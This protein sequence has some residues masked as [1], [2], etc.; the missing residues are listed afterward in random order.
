[1]SSV[2][3]VHPE[4]TLTISIHQAITK[5]SLFQKNSSLL[6]SPYRVESPVSLSIFRE[7]VSAL[8]GNVIT[9][10]VTNL[11][12]L[13]RLCQE[14]G[15]DEFAAKLSKFS[16]LLKDSQKRQ[17]GTPLSGMRS[18]LLGESFEFFV[19]G[20]VIE[21][22]IAE[23]AALFPA[24]R[25]QLSVDGCAR[26]FFVNCSE[27]E[28]ADILSLQLLLSGEAISVR[29]SQGLLSG[30]LGNVSFERLFLDCSK[31]DI[32]MNLSDLVIERRIDLES[33]DLSF[34]SFEALESLFLSESISVESEDAL[35]Q[36]I[37]KLSPD[38][39]NLLSHIRIVF[40][41]EDGLSLLDKHFG[42][43]PESVWQCAVERIAHPPLPPLL[44]FDSQII[45]DIPEIFAE[46]R[47]KQFQLLWRGSRDG[48]GAAE[49]HRRCDGHGNTLT[50]ILDT[51]GNIFGGFTPVEW[52]S[53]VYSQRQGDGDNCLKAD[54]S[55]KSFLFTLKNPHN[56]PAKRFAL[57]TE[58]KDRA[59]IC[60]SR[61]CPRFGHCT[62]DIS[63]DIGVCDN[64]NTDINNCTS[65]GCSYTNDNGLYGKT[66]FTG[67]DMFQVR[68][69]EVFEI[70]V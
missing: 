26:K 2:I 19:N 66:F 1:M 18:S 33:S 28:A 58:A 25:E 38:Y 69:I 53:R 23:A 63:C 70:T 50:V 9:I 56:I 14:F 29:R 21:I 24:V 34:L 57:K 60:D 31:A 46:F 32:R 15:F 67:S 6:V 39:R 48:F 37:L 16:P 42:I 44:P 30:L 62:F 40:L 17:I 11:T 5:C 20:T 61:W 8:E 47:K 36:F 59:I 12:G 41:S 65:L 45:S 35:L 54:E 51:K 22:D 55:L 4:E 10:T 27:I 52:E 3:L 49:F 68:E 64:C 13:E 7:F 43:P